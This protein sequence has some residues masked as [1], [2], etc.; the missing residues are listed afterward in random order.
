MNNKPVHPISSIFLDQDLLIN[1]GSGNNQ[2]KFDFPRQVST[3]PTSRMSVSNFSVPYSWFNITQAFGNNQF[4]YVWFDGAST[5]TLYPSSSGKGGTVVNITLPDGFYDLPTLNAYLQYIMVQNGH[6][7]IDQNGDYVYYL[8]FMYNVTSY[9]IQLNSYQLPNSLPSGWTAGSGVSFTGANTAPFWTPKLVLITNPLTNSD[10]SVN[11]DLFDFFGFSNA[12]QYLTQSAPGF[13]YPVRIL[14]ATSYP[15][16][17]YSVQSQNA[18]NSPVQTPVHC[19]CL[20]CNYIDNPIRS[21]SQH[22]VSTFVVTTQNITSSFGNDISNSNFFTTWIPLLA[23]Q[24]I[25]TMYFSL[26]DQE[27]NPIILQDPD[28]NI[29]LLITDLRYS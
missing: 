20:T 24:T 23:N 16:A 5:S 13:S 1:L 15:L 26:L 9:R 12:G 6:Y 17:G 22:A 7:L 11:P 28:S 25:S 21:N 14:P 27:G 10:P 3:T 18:E 4:A 2:F 29:E 19:I 8:E